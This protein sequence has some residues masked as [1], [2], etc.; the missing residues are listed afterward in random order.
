MEEGR[1]EAEEVKL[2]VSLWDNEW[3]KSLG[4]PNQSSLQAIATPCRY[5]EGR[6]V[7]PFRTVA[8]N[9]PPDETTCQ[10]CNSPGRQICLSFNLKYLKYLVELC[11]HCHGDIEA[12]HESLTADTGRLWGLKGFCSPCRM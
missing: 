9:T 4:L 1:S 2:L 11:L 3:Q 5:S 7:T 6:G 8:V 10:L 12:D